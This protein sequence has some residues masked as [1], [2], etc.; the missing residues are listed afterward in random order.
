MRI[1]LFSFI[2]LFIFS[3]CIPIKYKNSFDSLGLNTQKEIL[4]SGLCTRNSYI[5]NIN[6]SKYKKLFIE[7][8]HLNNSCT[9]NGLP[10]GYFVYQFKKHF[11]ITSMKKIERFDYENY[12]FTTY[13]IDNKYYIDLIYK[14]N[15]KQDLFILDYEGLY[16]EELIQKYDKSYINK[17]LN[18]SRFDKDYFKSLVKMDIVEN[19]FEKIYLKD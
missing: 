17:N 4:T 11:N 15:F 12:E 16:F 13:L 6:D 14:F 9:W 3:G 5:K 2:T 18:K 8:I 10:R 19:Y 7:Y 1:L